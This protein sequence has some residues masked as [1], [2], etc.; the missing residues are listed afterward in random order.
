MTTAM[1]ITI[2]GADD[3]NT[4]TRL[5]SSIRYGRVPFGMVKNSNPITR[6]RSV[7]NIH[8]SSLNVETLAI[9]LAVTQDTTQSHKAGYA[10]TKREER[11]YPSV[12]RQ[13][14]M[15]MIYCKRNTTSSRYLY[16]SMPHLRLDD[17]RFFTG[18]DSVVVFIDADDVR[19]NQQINRFLE[20]YRSHLLTVPTILFLIAEE[21]FQILNSPSPTR[22]TRPTTEWDFLFHHFY[23][24]KEKGSVIIKYIDAQHLH[25]LSIV[26][27]LIRSSMDTPEIRRSH[28]AS[29]DGKYPDHSKIPLA[30]KV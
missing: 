19:S 11:E 13:K 1:K 3:K 21:T 27:I 7:V 6:F 4:V 2:I 9:N 17:I 20:T 18:C 15:N 14:E 10:R 24:C 23:H 30:V 28:R 8:D 5:A 12:T 26:D 22:P 16:R 29:C 25:T